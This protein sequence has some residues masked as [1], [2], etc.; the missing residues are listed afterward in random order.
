M[1][2]KLMEAKQKREEEEKKLKQLN[3]SKRNENQLKYC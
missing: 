3:A 1:N 2:K